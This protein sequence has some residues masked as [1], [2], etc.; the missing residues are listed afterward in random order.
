MYEVVAVIESRLRL[1]RGGEEERDREEW[2]GR[3]R[4]RYGDKWKTTR[5]KT[6][7]VFRQS[8]GQ[9]QRNTNW[10]WDRKKDTI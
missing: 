3:D 6:S 10:L 5:E 4:E 1:E 2:W 7:T 8:D 9:R